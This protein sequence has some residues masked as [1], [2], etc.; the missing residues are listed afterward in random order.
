MP[1]YR[2]GPV[3]AQM[4]SIGSEGW[5]AKGKYDP[6]ASVSGQYVNWMNSGLKGAP[7]KYF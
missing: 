3:N 7:T 6:T 1:L 5:R 2:S 4:V